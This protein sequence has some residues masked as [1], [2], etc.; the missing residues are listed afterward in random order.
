MSLFLLDFDGIISNFASF[1]K[2][3]SRRQSHIRQARINQGAKC[4][5]SGETREA[6][7]K[8]W[9]SV[10]IESEKAAELPKFTLNPEVATFTE[11]GSGA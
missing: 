2:Q 9:K 11:R 5:L 3:Q 6:N 7:S 10:K 8:P 1:W 4:S